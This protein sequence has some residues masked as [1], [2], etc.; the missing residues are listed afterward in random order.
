MMTF[1]LLMIGAGG[2]FMLC[3]VLGFF[4]GWPVTLKDFEADL[5]AIKFD[6]SQY[7]EVEMLVKR[8]PETGALKRTEAGERWLK[9]CNEKDVK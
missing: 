2:G 6:T 7:T 3:W 1:A 8:D 5:K 4:L 9:E